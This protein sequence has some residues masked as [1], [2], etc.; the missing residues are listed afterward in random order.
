VKP[1]PGSLSHR[2]P[3]SSSK[4]ARGAARDKSTKPCSTSACPMGPMRLLDEVGLGRRAHH[5]FRGR[6]PNNIPTRLCV[7][8][9]FGQN[10]ERRLSRQKN[11]GVAFY[12]HTQKRQKRKLNH[13]VESFRAGNLAAAI[14][15][16]RTPRTHGSSN[17]Q[18]SH[19]LLG[20]TSCGPR[21]TT[22]ISGMVMGTGFRAIS[23]VGLYAMAGPPRAL[24]TSSLPC[25]GGL[26]RVQLVFEPCAPS[27]KHGEWWEKNFMASPAR[28]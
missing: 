8:A 18:R 10:V 3:G 24:K 27:P 4:P 25:A 16:R 20:R 22:W 23:A 28:S 1:H 6:S 7:P 26:E 12:V 15:P 13:P 21:R 11:R 9:N 5:I 2:G 14:H 19:T 17:G